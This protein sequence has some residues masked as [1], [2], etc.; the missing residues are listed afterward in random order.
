MQI[1]LDFENMSTYNEL[2]EIYDKIG[3]DYFCEWNNTSG[4]TLH[5][6]IFNTNDFLNE[7]E[8]LEKPPLDKLN[9]LF[10]SLNNNEQ[11]LQLPIIFNNEWRFVDVDVFYCGLHIKDIDQNNQFDAVN[12]KF[13][14]T[15]VKDQIIDMT[16]YY[17]IDYLIELSDFWDGDY[18]R[19]QIDENDN[20]YILHNKVAIFEAIV[21]K[22]NRYKNIKDGVIKK[23]IKELEK[24]LIVLRDKNYNDI[25]KIPK[26]NYEL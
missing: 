12:L 20:I 11:K 8:T 17:D 14:V 7:N 22:I 26:L 9:K 18:Y 3:V 15:N 1:L 16:K 10:D 21:D 5:K 19:F 2:M 4:L 13:W 6:M 23:Y 25:I 24:T